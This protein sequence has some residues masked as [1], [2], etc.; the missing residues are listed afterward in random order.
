[1]NKSTDS[2]ISALMNDAAIMTI[3]HETLERAALTIEEGTD[4]IEC[5]SKDMV[6]IFD[7]RRMLCSIVSTLW[8]SL[9]F[10]SSERAS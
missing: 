1:M 6:Y 9:F 7:N 10:M 8:A 2:E 5:H 4:V 3:A